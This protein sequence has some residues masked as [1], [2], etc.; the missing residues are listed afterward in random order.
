VEP[1]LRDSIVDFVRDW[2]DKTELASF[3]L[4]DWIGIG[5][6]KYFDWKRRY[7]KVNEHNAWIP[8]DH[9]L[10]NW[11]KQTIVDYYLAHP[12][13]GYRRITYMMMDENLVAT[14]PSS[15]YRVLTQAD[16]MRRWNRKP[17]QKGTGF[18]QP[19][20]PHQHWH[21]DISYVN[22]CGTFYYLCSILDGYSRGIVHHEIREQ[23]KEQDVEII[24]QRALEVYPG[25]HPRIIS[26][27]GPQFIAKDFK[28]YLKCKGM[29][30]VRTSPYYPQSNG[31]IERWHQSLKRECI[32]PK[33]PLTLAD[34]QRVV[35]KFVRHYNTE[36]LHSAIGYVT[37]EDKLNGRDIEIFAERDRKLQAAREKRAMNRRAER[38]RLDFVA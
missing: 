16:V 17:S 4:V 33:A 19:L 18:V 8:R 3:Q 37:P 30:Q 25:I 24:L 13:D 9:W 5:T 11:E 36:R 32:R 28:Q 22:V 15:V 2:S 34:A 23:M 20:Q 31:K 6:S 10:E 35:S 38:K 1:D 21:I 27:N 12:D 29:D 26:D 14:S 7:G